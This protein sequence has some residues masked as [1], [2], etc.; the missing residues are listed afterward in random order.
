MAF[1][2]REAG[3]VFRCDDHLVTKTWTRMEPF[4]DPHLRLLVLVV[5]GCIDEV[6]ALGMEIVQQ[7]KDRFFGHSSQHA[8]PERCQLKLRRNKTSERRITMLRQNSLLRYI[9][10]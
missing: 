4:A 8:G 2:R 5:V 1:V 7:F 3:R 6:S 9:V 10:G